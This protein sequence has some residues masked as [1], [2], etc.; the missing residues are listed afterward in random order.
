[1]KLFALDLGNRQ[2]KLKSEKATKVLPA[3]FVDVE[4]Y[5]KRDVL[6]L[7]DTNK[8]TSDYVSHRDSD[9]TYVWGEDLRISGKHLMDTIRFNNRYNSTEFKLLADFA[10]AELARDFKES[11]SGVL[12]VVVVT[13]VPT[14]DYDNEDVVGNLIKVLKGVHSVDID[15]K[16][17]VVRVHKVYVLMQP[18]GTAIN[19][20]VD[21]NGELIDDTDIEDGYIGVVDCGGGT[22][23]IDAF[24]AMN[25]DTKNRVQLKDGAYSLYTSIRNKVS[26]YE[27]SEHEVER[28]VRNGNE[29]ELYVWSPNGREH[30]NLTSIVMKER[31]RYTLKVIQSIGTTYKDIGRM[32][33]I[34]FTGGGA[35]LLLQEEIEDSF[36]IFRFVKNSE[37]AN[38][39]GFYKYG[40]LNEVTSDGDEITD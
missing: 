29:D 24:D 34:Y 5:G 31:K 30:L 13:G 37:L 23:I 10:L 6:V 27:I 12:D 7:K 14:N 18:T 25:L 8:K 33:A 36:P 4:E 3:Y 15:G 40:L 32:K 21:D 28:V 22:L 39:N 1:M 9:F 35:N 20:M 11:R 16:T 17:H 26:N 2:V 19:E 38:L